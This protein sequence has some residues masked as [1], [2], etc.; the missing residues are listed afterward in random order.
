M[1]V[2]AATISFSDI[3]SPARWLE[4][5]LLASILL[6]IFCTGIQ[7]IPFHPDESQWIATS[8]AFEAYVSGDFASPTWNEALWTLTQPPG[9]RYII[10]LGRLAGGYHADQLNVPWS[11]G[12]DEPTNIAAG[13]MPS[14]GLLWWSRLPMALVSV[15]SLL[16]LFRLVSVTAGRIAGYMCLLLVT[17]NPFM[18]MT[19]RRA[20]AEAPLLLCLM[21]TAAANTA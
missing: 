21:L 3:T 4:I 1:T 2:R 20:M 9:T 8:G 18:L 5:P 17:S 12:R 14:P 11:F 19:L 16:L 13:A 6:F 15:V 7:A 10:A